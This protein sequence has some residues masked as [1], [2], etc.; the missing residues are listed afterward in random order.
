M[1]RSLFI[2]FLALSALSSFAIE[3]VRTWTS[4]SGKTIEAAFVESRFGEVILQTPDGEKMRIRLNQLSSK[5]QIYAGSASRPSATAEPEVEANPELVKLFGSRL[6]NAKGKSV[7]TAELNGKKV[8][9]YFSA[10]WCPPCR[11]SIPHLT[12]LAH[13]FTDVSFIGMNIWERGADVSRDSVRA[14][15]VLALTLPHFT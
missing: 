3:E 15:H 7:S 4:A 9:L 5:D 13:E 14:M 11:T 12:E 8:G 6:V 2:L 1:K 10:S